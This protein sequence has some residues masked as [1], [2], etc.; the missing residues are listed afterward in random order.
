MTAGQQT[1][2]LTVSSTFGR[3]RMVHSVTKFI[4]H[5][6]KQVSVCYSCWRPFV[7]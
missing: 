4:W 5:F 2:Q 3:R 6:R 1:I 7:C